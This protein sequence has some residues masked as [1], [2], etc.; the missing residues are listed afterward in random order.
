MARKEV[1]ISE[2]TACHICENSFDPEDMT[3]CP[4]YGKAICSLCCNLDVRC[5]DQ[6]RPHATLSQQAHDFFHRFLNTK[7]L[8]KMT[9]PLIQFIA[10]TIGLSLVGADY[11]VFNIFTDPR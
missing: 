7:L 4:A 11:S 1:Q 10:V 5:G 9:T 8:N 6:C 2:I 3:F